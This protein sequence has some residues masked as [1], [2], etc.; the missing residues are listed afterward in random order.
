MLATGN[1]GNDLPFIEV[2]VPR[3]TTQLRVEDAGR[4]TTV[5]VEGSGVVS[6]R[7]D[8]APDAPED[9][10][11]RVRVTALNADGAPIASAHVNA[12]VSTGQDVYPPT[13][14]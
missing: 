3:G 12:G 6:V 7:H 4:V 13:P 2:L 10:G 9:R 11:G 1:I 14:S 8:F 5:P